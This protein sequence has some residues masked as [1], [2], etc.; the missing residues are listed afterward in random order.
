MRQNLDSKDATIESLQKKLESKE[1][2]IVD[3]KKT[4]KISWNVF[5]IARGM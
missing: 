2:S 4:K 1:K 3:M 5:D